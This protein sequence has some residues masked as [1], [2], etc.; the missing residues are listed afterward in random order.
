MPDLWHRFIA[1]CYS[2][3]KIILQNI[4]TYPIY[5]YKCI[6]IVKT[7]TLARVNTSNQ[8]YQEIQKELL[9]QLQPCFIFDLVGVKNNVIGLRILE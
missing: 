8:G 5:E 4:Q 9:F 3:Q 1:Y 7:L 6:K 2:F